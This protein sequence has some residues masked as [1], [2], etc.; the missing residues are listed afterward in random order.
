MENPWT[1]IHYRPLHKLFDR[2]L[3]ILLR[4]VQIFSSLIFVN[5]SSSTISSNIWKC[6]HNLRKN[7]VSATLRVHPNSTPSQSNSD[8][9]ASTRFLSWFV[10]SR[11]AFRFCRASFEECCCQAAR[12]CD[13]G[14]GR[15]LKNEIRAEN[16]EQVR[17][18]GVHLFASKDIGRLKKEKGGFS[19]RS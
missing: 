2:Y 7:S 13:G 19:D 10:A 6:L 5:F 16:A 15:I 4:N 11:G 3:A 1:K 12:W 9:R 18:T 14:R 8:K 17:S